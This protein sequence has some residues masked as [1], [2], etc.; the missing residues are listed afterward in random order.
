MFYTPLT[1][2]RDCVAIME[3][4]HFA[5]IPEFNSGIQRVLIDEK[6]FWITWSSQVMTKK[7]MLLPNYDTVSQEGRYTHASLLG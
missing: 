3:R 7:K 4:V 2:L 1:P 6:N 5:V